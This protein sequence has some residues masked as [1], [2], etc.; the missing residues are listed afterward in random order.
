MPWH[1]CRNAFGIHLLAPFHGGGKQEIVSR[2]KCYAFDAGFVAYERGWEQMR[3]EDRGLLWEHLVLV[4][5]YG[6]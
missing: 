4:G 2:P 1:E 3:E 6:L 5:V